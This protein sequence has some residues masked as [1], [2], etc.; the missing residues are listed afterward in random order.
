MNW[1]G[2]GFK[3]LKT[4][5]ISVLL[6]CLHISFLV[7]GPFTM[8]KIFLVFRKPACPFGQVKTKMYLP[9]S[10]FSKNSLAGAS[11]LVLMSVPVHIL[12]FQIFTT[13]CKVA[14]RS[15]A[16]HRGSPLIG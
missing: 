16:G 3:D 1:L 5:F 9:E 7:F 14:E 13:K 8:K 4:S 10:P 6:H 15:S 12:Q 2:H 11:G